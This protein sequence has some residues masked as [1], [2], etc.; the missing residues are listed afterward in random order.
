VNAWIRSTKLFDAV[1][2]LAK[3]V[4]DPA[5][6]QRL[7]PAYDHDHIHPNDAGH[8]AMADAIDLRLFTR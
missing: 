8:K 1:I 2:D 5:D 6:P 4:E 3:V 7:L